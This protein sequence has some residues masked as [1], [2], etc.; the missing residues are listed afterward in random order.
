MFVTECDF[1]EDH[2]FFKRKK[3][4]Y[5][6]M[7]FDFQL[8]LTE[9]ETIELL[10]KRG[11]LTICISLIKDGKIYLRRP[12]G[13]RDWFTALQ[14]RNPIFVPCIYGLTSCICKRSHKVNISSS[15]GPHRRLN[16]HSYSIVSFNQSELNLPNTFGKYFSLKWVQEILQGRHNLFD[17]QP[18]FLCLFVKKK[19][20]K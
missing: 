4:S 18:L 6:V 5:K 2:M 3:I 16:L 20:S 10:D 8:K 11:Y 14:V 12:E 1:F 7:P 9:V 15:Q 17:F 13:I 19:G